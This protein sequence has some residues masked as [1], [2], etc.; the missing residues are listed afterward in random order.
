M[1]EESE[2][3]NVTSSFGNSLQERPMF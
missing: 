2:Q 1:A 3:D